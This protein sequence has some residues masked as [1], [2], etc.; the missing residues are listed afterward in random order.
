MDLQSIKEAGYREELLGDASEAAFSD[1][2]ASFT[3]IVRKVSDE[4]QRVYVTRF[5]KPT[6]AIVPINDLLRLMELDHETRQ[7]M[8]R[9][10]KADF[11]SDAEVE[12][13]VSQHDVASADES[14]DDILRDF[15]EKIAEL[16]SRLPAVK[17]LVH[18]SMQSRSLA[19]SENH[20][21]GLSGVSGVVERQHLDVTAPA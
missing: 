17:E 12:P 13:F 10:M 20:T 8:A 7:K 4:G 2:R 11:L 16:E 5:G 3:S 9:N 19:A 18:N 6:V 1:A 15:V 21:G 14:E